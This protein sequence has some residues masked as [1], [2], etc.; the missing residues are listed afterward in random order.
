M[1]NLLP[2]DSARQLR[3]ARHNSIL[4]RYA[5][6]AAIILC[7][8]VLVYVT[9]YILFKTTESSNAAASEEN[10]AKISAYSETAAAAKKYQ[11]NLQRAKNIFDN[12][13]SYPTALARISA[14]LPE[15]TVLSSLT[16]SP[17]TVNQPITLTIEAKT[18]EAALDVK[19]KFE[20]NNIATDISISSLSRQTTNATT[21]GAQTSE[22]PYTINL[23]LTLQDAI[24]KPTEE[25]TD[26]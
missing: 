2:P 3:A 13:I 6:G 26:G 11:S 7:L 1:I 18:Q 19:D 15:G 9:A 23:N 10:Q 14:G 5:I 12:E 8:I 22:Y 24:L 25:K 4:I 17:E 16:L 20:R 21:E